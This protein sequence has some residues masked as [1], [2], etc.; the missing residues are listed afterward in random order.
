MAKFGEDLLTQVIH[1]EKKL[2]LIEPHIYSLHPDPDIEHT[3]DTLF[4][5]IYDR[6]ACSSL[7]NRLVWGYSISTLAS[8]V[9]EALELSDGGNLLDIGCGA[10]AFS[11]ETYIHNTRRPAVL[12]DQSLKMLQMAKTRLMRSCGQ[13]PQNMV[14]LHGDALQLPFI[15]G[16]FDTIISLNLLHC[17]SDTGLLLDGI[18][19]VLTGNGRIYFTTLV[20]GSRLADKYLEVLAQNGKLFSRAMDDLERIFQEARTP[21]KYDVIGN[22]AVIRA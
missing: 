10:L 12:M 22:M 7:Y 20:R 4:G 3:Y 14:F 9:H 2:S 15:D 1:G 6:I 5:N 21:I 16:S 18:K 8:V 13:V 19:R 11:A 17:I